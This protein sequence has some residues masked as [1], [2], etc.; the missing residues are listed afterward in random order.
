LLSID[1]AQVVASGLG[2]LWS[3]ARRRLYSVVLPLAVGLPR[4][5]GDVIGLVWP[6][7]DLPGGRV[8][9]IV[10]EQIRAGDSTITYLVL[11]SGG[12]L[13]N[14]DHTSDFNSDFT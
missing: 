4:D 14:R 11:V 10:G 1:G 9:Q 13:S 12:A 8:G 2:G 7:D 5:I 3:A 6:M